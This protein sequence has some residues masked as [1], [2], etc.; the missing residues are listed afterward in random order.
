MTN[1]EKIQ[2]KLYHNRNELVPM[3]QEWKTAQKKIVFTNGCFDL[4]HAGHVDYLSKAADLGDILIVGLNSDSS[5]SRLKG[6]HRPITNEKSRMQVLASFFFIDAVV[7]FDE[8]TPYELIQMIVPNVLVK[9]GD[10]K[11]EDVVGN[12]VVTKN[13]GKTI[14]L[15]FVPGYSTSL[16]EKKIVEQFQ[17]K[18]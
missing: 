15:D 12:D 14:I 2:S 17:K 1:I 16:I 18:L 3:L 4:M 11:S 10:Y 8:H 6:P 13:G 5:V 7:I 9:G